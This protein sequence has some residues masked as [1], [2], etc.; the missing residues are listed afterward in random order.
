MGE[1][2]RVRVTL[3]AATAVALSA[4]L[5]GPA[6]ASHTGGHEATREA[7]R[8]AVRDG[9]PGAT[10]TARDARGTWRATEGVG[11]LRTGAPRS[12][13][14]RYRVGSITKTFVATVLLQLE[15]VLRDRPPLREQ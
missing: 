9:V 13:A 14:D 12:V 11:D 6:L 2:M 8:A 3:V 4:A 15:A 5:V 10:A 7:L 1:V